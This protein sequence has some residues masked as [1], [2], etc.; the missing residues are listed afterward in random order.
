MS[1][2]LLEEARREIDRVDRE[3][4]RLFEARMEAAKKVAVY[5][6]ETGMPIFDA[7]REKAIIER[8]AAR[9]SDETVRG[10]Y[11]SFLHSVMDL[12]KAYQ[13]RLISGMNVA[14]SG[15]PGAFAH[16]AAMRIFPDATPIGFS[17]F[18]EAYRAVEEG[19]CDAAVL[20]LEN[21]VGGDVGTVMDLAFFGSLSI[22]GI[23]D[24]EV[25]QN[26]LAKPG[27]HLSDIKTVTSHPQ[28][29][30]QCAGFLS[31]TGLLTREAVNTAVAA[32]LVSE[33]DDPSLAAIGSESAAE[34]YGL[35]ILRSRIQD[36]GQNTTRFAVFSRTEKTVSAADRQLVMVFTVKNEAGALA[37]AVS[38]IGTHGFN[39]RAIK[40]RPTKHLSWEYY[41]F[42]EGEGRIRSEEGEKMLS[43]LREN[44]NDLRVLGSFEK[45]SEV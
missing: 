38:A 34:E 29:L 19:R 13:S 7:S 11:V 44:C 40:S 6:K 33:G 18:A 43:L 39:L 35:Q 41:F 23:Y 31:K 5:K 30:A 36:K 32:K 20:P 9:V 21:S 25:E 45:E 14:F 1:E 37:K 2:S 4:A 12:S 22:N 28:A 17:D 10:Y 16:L 3:M 15:V 8:G 42:C 24:V 26:L 27:V